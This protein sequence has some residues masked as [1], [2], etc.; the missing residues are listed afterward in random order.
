MVNKV[1]FSKSYVS[2]KTVQNTNNLNNS[3][4]IAEETNLASEVFKF[5]RLT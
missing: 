2:L 5:T 1:L 3:C 4:P